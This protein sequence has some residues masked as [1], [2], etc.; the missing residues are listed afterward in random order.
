MK[1]RIIYLDV[2]EKGYLKMKHL[3]GNCKDVLTIS[4]ILIGLLIYANSVAVGDKIRMDPA[5]NLQQLGYPTDTVEHILAAT[6]SESYFVRHQA[7][8]VLTRRIGKEAIST[9]KSSLADVRVEV[10]YRAAHFLGTLGDMSGLEQMR[11]DLKDLAPH[12]GVPPPPD[13]NADPRTVKRKEARRNFN[14]RNALEVAKVLAELGD[15][16]GYELAARMALD[17][18]LAAQRYTAVFVLVEIAKTD[19]AILQTEGIAPVPILCSMAESE[20]KRI[21]FS[22]LVNSVQ[23]LDADIAIPI[24]EIAKNSPNQTELSRRAAQITLNMV[25]DK[26]IKNY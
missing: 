3:T 21:V 20:K 25:K 15:R 17:G 5:K 26:G 10:R 18:P 6:R 2:L 11:K 14:L 8:E 19:K 1:N 12:D 23:K 4:V 7:L 22:I 9:L 13:P 24:L 16:C